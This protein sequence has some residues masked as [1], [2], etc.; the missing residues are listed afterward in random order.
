MRRQAKAVNFGIVY[1]ISDYGLSQNLNITRKEA[2]SFIEQYF[3]VF[4]GVR[5]Y[6]DDI[7]K[8]ARRD[9]LRDDAAAAPPISAGDYRFELQSALI[10]RAHGDEYA[11]SRHSSRYYQA[12]DG[13]DGRATEAGR[14]REAGCCFKYTMSSYS[15]C[16]KKSWR[17]MRRIVPEVMADALKLDVPLSADVDF[18]LTWYEAK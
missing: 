5:K 15:K 16:L 14:T 18:G 1:G 9:G 13:A 7:V 3:A 10:C 6:M 2:A 4:Q 12:G 11:N 17:S 8:D